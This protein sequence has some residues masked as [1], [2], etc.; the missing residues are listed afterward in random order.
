MARL[1]V[2]E[3]ASGARRPAL[4]QEVRIGIVSP[5]IAIDAHNQSEGT[6]TIL[7]IVHGRREITSKLLS[8]PR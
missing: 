6:V 4:G 8:D 2:T 1:I 7:R 3:S 5:F